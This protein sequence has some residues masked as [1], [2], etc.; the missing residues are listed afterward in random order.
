VTVMTWFTAIYFQDKL[1]QSCLDAIILI[2]NPEEKNVAHITI[3]GPH[4]RRD[5]QDE[6]VKE[7]IGSNISVL[8]T[9]R[10]FQENQNTVYLECGSQLLRKYWR[11]RDYGYNPHITLYDG[12]SRD[13]AEKLF[14]ILRNHKLFFCVTVGDVLFSESVKGQSAFDLWFGADLNQ[15]GDI[16]GE[17]I[18]VERLGTLPMWK[19]LNM[20]DRLCTHLVWLN[21]QAV[22]R[23]RSPSPH[24]AAAQPAG[25]RRQ[26]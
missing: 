12:R 15:I 2:A 20:I 4:I 22:T 3:R 8:G 19:R 7:L 18:D 23:R 25:T 13:F 10:F 21:H 24:A 5:D 17:R 14:L 26:A 16:T 9:G 6:A 11:K 1:V